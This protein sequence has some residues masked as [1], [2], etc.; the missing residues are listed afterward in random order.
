[1]DGGSW[2]CTGGSYQ[3]HPQE[4]EM[5]LTIAPNKKKYLDINTVRYLQSHYTEHYKKS[6]KIKIN[7][8]LYKD[9]I[10][11]DSMVLKC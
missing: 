3:D 5:Q 9:Y 4:K 11:E 8:K 6:K 2:S 10:L 7:R 1:M